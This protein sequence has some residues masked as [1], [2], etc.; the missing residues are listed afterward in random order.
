MKP[1]SSQ[2]MLASNS[3]AEEEHTC[4]HLRWAESKTLRCWSAEFTWTEGI[5][6]GT[7]LK[8]PSIA[9]TPVHQYFFLFSGCDFNNNLNIFLLFLFVSIKLLLINT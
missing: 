4:R 3:L 5:D 2:L 6:M 7:I 1:T 9:H 8:Q